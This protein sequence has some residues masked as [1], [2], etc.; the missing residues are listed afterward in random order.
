VYDYADCRTILIIEDICVC[1]CVHI[2]ISMYICTYTYDMNIC[3]D[4]YIYIHIYIYVWYICIYVY[5]HMIC[6]S[7]YI[8][9]YIYIYVWYT[10]ICEYDVC[11]NHV[12]GVYDAA[13]WKEEIG[14]HVTEIMKPWTEYTK[15][16][17]A[18]H[19]GDVPAAI[20][21]HH[22]DYDNEVSFC[23]HIY[24][25]ALQFIYIYVLK[26]IYIYICA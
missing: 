11:T 6:I 12:T 18:H 17:D 4:L 14:D 26:F 3:I 15:K 20:Y 16:A 22:P 25:Y 23:G 13:D 7:V 5:I 24:I 10:Y 8:Y 9:T 1:V 21:S 2:Y 19:H